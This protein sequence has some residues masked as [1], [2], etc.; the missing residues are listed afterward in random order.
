MKN[1]ISKFTGRSQT[2]LSPIR[3]S[4]LKRLSGSAITSPRHQSHA[5]CPRGLGLAYCVGYRKDAP[6][7]RIHAGGIADVTPCSRDAGGGYRRFDHALE[8]RHACRSSEVP[9]SSSVSRTHAALLRPAGEEPSHGGCT[10]GWV[11]SVCASGVCR[12]AAW[13]GSYRRDLIFRASPHVNLAPRS[14][15]AQTV[16]VTRNLDAAATSVSGRPHCSGC[17]GVEV[18]GRLC[19][20]RI[21]HCPPSL[22]CRRFAFFHV[23]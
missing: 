16:V 6:F 22:S 17:R 14:P 1:I 12:N 7:A 23:T 18:S 11:A 13:G 8:K 9:S 10:K 3:Q 2:K 19:L 5:P 20:L 4:Q 21:F 15:L